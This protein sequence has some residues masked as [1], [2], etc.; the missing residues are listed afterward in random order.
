MKIIDFK[1]YLDG[2]TIE[3]TTDM[4][5]YSFDNRIK[6]D[7]KGRLYLGMPF[8]DNRNLI[9]DSL[10]LENEIITALKSYRNSFYQNKI[11]SLI[12]EY[13]NKQNL[14]LEFKIEAFDSEGQGICSAQQALV[15]D[16]KNNKQEYLILHISDCKYRIDKSGNI[17]E[18]IL[19]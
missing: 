12:K 9:Q 6:S 4:G 10:E 14:K 17:L 18:K 16:I 1:V 8:K 11:D 15:L 2:G 3:I 19:Q 13:E 5:I 7:T